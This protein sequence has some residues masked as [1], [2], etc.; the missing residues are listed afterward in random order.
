MERTRLEV[1]VIRQG[2]IKFKNYADKLRMMDT[3]LF[4]FGLKLHQQEG[5]IQFY[6]A[7]FLNTI[8]VSSAHFLNTTLGDCCN[9]VNEALSLSGFK[10][11]SFQV[12]Q[13]KEINDFDLKEAMIGSSHK[14]KITL[15]FNSFTDTLNAHLALS[16]Y[17][18]TNSVGTSSKIISQFFE[19][20][21]MYYDGKFSTKFES[22]IKDKFEGLEK[23]NEIRSDYIKKRLIDNGIQPSNRFAAMLNPD[24]KMQE[25]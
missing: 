10:G 13:L 12:G 5:H 21:P 7:D 6:D 3:A 8:Q 16:N 23:T 2:F 15:R 22:C 18:H 14:M 1:P 11:N 25:M 20:A 17:V 4:L 19:P 9:M 24:L